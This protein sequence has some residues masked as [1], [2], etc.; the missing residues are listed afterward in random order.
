MTAAAVFDA[1]SHPRSRPR[2]DLKTI[3]LPARS[4]AVEV[5]LTHDVRTTRRHSRKVQPIYPGVRCRDRPLSDATLCGTT[6]AASHPSTPPIQVPATPPHHC[7]RAAPQSK[8]SSPGLSH[9]PQRLLPAHAP[10]LLSPSHATPLTQVPGISNKTTAILNSF[11]NNIFKREEGRPQTAV[12]LIL[13][14]ELSKHAISEGTRAI[15]LPTRDATQTGALRHRYFHA[16]LN[17]FVNDIFE[18]IAKNPPSRQGK[19]RLLFV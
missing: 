10:S 19:S 14:G 11:V 5:A 17:S 2:L 8:G 13:P 18:R 7:P 4:V 1:T 16:V 3:A 15:A 12:R 9:L 6:S